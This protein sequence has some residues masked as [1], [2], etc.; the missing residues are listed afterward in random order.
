MT[1]RISAFQLKIWIDMN[2]SKKKKRMNWKTLTVNLILKTADEKHNMM[3]K[4]LNC[5][6]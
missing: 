5:N 2:W 3:D 4:K 6:D 1:K